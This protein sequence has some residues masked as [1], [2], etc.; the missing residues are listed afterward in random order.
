[1]VT[2]SEADFSVI[3]P[4]GPSSIEVERLGDTLDSLAAH[5][6]SACIRLIIVDDSPVPRQLADHWPSALVIRTTLWENGTTDP[7]SAHTAGTLEALKRAEGAF[8]LK[9]DTDAVVIAP[10]AEAITAAFRRDDRLGVVGAFETSPQGRARDWS[11]WP[12]VIGR[13]TW[14]VRAAR[15]SG[16]A[17]P[18]LGWRSKAERDAARRI[19]SAAAANP[20]YSLGAHCLGG[21]YAVSAKLLELSHEW[22]WNPFVGSQLG[23]DVTLG[24]HCGACG[25][26]M[27]GMVDEGDP[28]GVS[29]IGLPDD[30]E[31]LV[32]RR[33]SI[34]HSVK[35][36]EYGS[37]WQ[38]RAWFRAHCR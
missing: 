19:I 20:E 12:R 5:V 13:T 6:G 3:V 35:D 18:S 24:L 31:S 14:P 37:E 30:P 29:W 27:R 28:F 4:V 10:F 8:A 17:L 7:L 9:L 21:A 38:L 22:D 26:R 23:E 2:A 36:C 16:K 32:R 34:V 15:I 33:Y 1:M 25:M 11:G